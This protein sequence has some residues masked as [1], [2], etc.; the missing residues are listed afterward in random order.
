[1]TQDKISHNECQWDIPWQWQIPEY[2]NIGFECTS[3]HLGGPKEEIPA[4][5]FEDDADG[6]SQCTYR[7][8]ARLSDIFAQFFQSQ[9]FAAQERMLLRYKNAAAY[10]I[11]FFGVLKAGGVAVPTSTLLSL[12]EVLYL[13]ED[14]EAKIM[15]TDSVTWSKLAEFRD[16]YSLEKVVLADLDSPQEAVSYKGIEIFALKEILEQFSPLEKH[17][18]TRPQDP[19]YLVYTSGTTG[20]PKGVLH[21]HKS[22]LGRT[23]ASKFWFN[24]S[25]NDRIMHSGKFNWTYVLG[26]AL[27]DPLYHGHTVIAYEGENNPHIW[28]DLIAKHKCSIFIGVP[29][30]YRQ[31][32][33]RTH[34]SLED[35]PSLRHCMSA[36]EHL[37]D[38][39]MNLWQ[40][41]FKQPIYEA[42]GMSEFS[43]Y[44]SQSTHRPIRPG[45][46]GFPQP[47]HEVV[48][49]NEAGIEVAKGET[50]V[51]A[52]PLEDPGL[53]LEYWKQEE[54]TQKVRNWGYFIT[55]DYARFDE[56][57]YLW[58]IG[59]K[60]DIINSFGYRI[61][62]H[63]IER[64]IKTHPTVAD[65]AVIGLEISS[66]KTLVTACIILKEGSS[67]DNITRIEIDHFIKDHIAN[68]KQPKLIYF[69]EDFPRTKNGKVL[70]KQLK[71]L[72]KN[73]WQ[74]EQLKAEK[75]SFKLASPLVHR[76]K[77]YPPRRT[78]H[79]VPCYRQKYLKK[80]LALDS[81]A[82]IFDLQDS[83]PHEFRAESRNNLREF[84][85]QAH[86]K[87]EK[88]IRINQLTCDSLADDINLLKGLLGQYSAV[89]LPHIESAKDVQR[90]LALFAESGMED[91][92]EIMINI[93]S[94]RG[95][96]NVAQILQDE[97]RITTVIMG[98]ADLSRGLRLRLD[99]R[100]TGILS[101]LNTVVLAARANDCCVIDGPHYEIHNEKSCEEAVLQGRDLGF[102]GKATI[103]P[104]QLIYTKE[105]FTP[106]N[107]DIEYAR[108]VLNEYKKISAQADNT[109]LFD[110]YVVDSS[111]IEWAEYTIN[112][113]AREG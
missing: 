36:G 76:R 5:I 70:R 102:D 88:I 87:S 113:S 49:L 67:R 85:P 106:R 22:L 35:V 95:V 60:D 50:G 107:S 79:Y 59:R 84:L 42:I 75:N 77:I 58:F 39:L 91:K 34:K 7:E 32:L 103:H 43:Y 63:E 111:L 18:E 23:P 83:V 1:M 112:F 3:K 24:F 69:F 86:L 4:M 81:D 14:S 19:A 62:P 61:S 27:M 57:G 11:G 92:F 97:E 16:L 12:P 98:T 17:A 73:K 6:V 47:G 74:G 64:A 71:E 72:T 30:I 54:E 82:F 80:T 45:S 8:L 68:Y 53:F 65:S 52:I 13:L 78:M 46:A 55:G 108:K 25:E 94:P 110:G 93:E 109:L 99:N 21:G 38:E 90:Y 96:L 15:L 44:I 100:R 28:I 29:T 26:S 37:S 66:D 56:D 89:L 20:Y 9:G 40:K 48:L 104:C 101:S 41:R 33:Q 10:P 51:I 105:A 2:F 31:I